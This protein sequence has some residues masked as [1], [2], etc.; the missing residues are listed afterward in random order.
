[1]PCWKLL[2]TVFQSTLSFC[3]SLPSLHT[4]PFLI[5]SFFPLAEL[6]PGWIPRDCVCIKTG[7]SAWKTAD[8]M[9]ACCNLKVKTKKLFSI[10]IILMGTLWPGHK[11]TVK[12]KWQT[13]LAYW[14]FYPR[15]QRNGT[16]CIGAIRLIVWIRGVKLKMPLNKTLTAELLQQRG[17]TVFI[18]Q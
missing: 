9:K 15:V 16:L 1:M 11:L 5:F 18:V 7:H 8:L 17:E 2:I 6:D 13:A 12:A 14:F 4:S 10:D 3:S